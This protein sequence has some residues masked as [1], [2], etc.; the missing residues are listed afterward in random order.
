ML[1]YSIIKD[2]EIDILLEDIY[3]DYGYD[4]LQYSRASMKRRI[5]R[6]MTNDRLASFAELRFVLKDNPA[7]LQHFVEEITVNLTEM[8]RDPLFFRQLREEILPQL[9]TYPLI[10]VW[11]AGCSTGEEAYSMSI[12]LKEANLYHKSL[13]YATDINPRVLDIARNGVYPLSQIKS[14]SENYIESGGKQD[15]SKYYTA[16]YEWA[17]FDA[18]LKQKMILSTHNLVSDT[19]FNSFQLILCRNVL[20]Y[21]NKDLQERVFK[22]FDASLENLGYLALGSKETIRFSGI[23]HNFTAVG[24]QKIWKKLY[25]L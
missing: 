4:F 3:R 11:I 16:N 20:I 7:F 13:I 22:L 6:L 2:H 5:N 10:R 8:F 15:F 25:T 24:D 21:F 23:Q 18:D 19:S 12:L 1:G 14:F 17:K 9:G